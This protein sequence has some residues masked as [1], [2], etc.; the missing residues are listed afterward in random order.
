MNHDNHDRKSGYWKWF[1]IK[2]KW[3]QWLTFLKVY[4][5]AMSPPKLL[6]FFMCKV[7]VFDV[8]IV[9]MQGEFFFF[10]L[11]L[12]QIKLSVEGI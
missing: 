12:L 5:T 1:L 3:K 10:L 4:H 9:T 2:Y 11:T 7:S 8:A 6:Y